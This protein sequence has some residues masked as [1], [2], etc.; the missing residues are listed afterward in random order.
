MTLNGCFCMAMFYGNDVSGVG[1]HYLDGSHQQV[2]AKQQQVFC[3]VDLLQ[4]QG[5]WQRRTALPDIFMSMFVALG[6]VTLNTTFTAV[7]ATQRCRY[8]Q[9]Q[10]CLSN[11]S[12]Y[13]I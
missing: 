5:Y 10:W 11:L 4:P 1:G 12:D 9:R 3:T 8:L 2:C 6:Q 7:S 13:I